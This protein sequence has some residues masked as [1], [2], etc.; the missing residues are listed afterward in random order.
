LGASSVGPME[1]FLTSA[2]NSSLISG[3]SVALNL[4]TVPNAVRELRF[5]RLS[6]DAPIGNDGARLGATVLYSDIWPSDDRRSVDTHTQMETYALKGS[7]VPIETKTSSLWL[8][9][10]AS[11]NEVIERNSLGTIYND[12]L[13]IASLTADYRLHDN[14]DGWNYLTLTFN[15]GLDVFGASNKGDLLLSRDGAPANFSI[16]DFSYTRY[17]NLSDAW[18]VKLATSGQL[19]SAP[20]LNSMQF[21]IGDPAYGPGFY[22]GD[23]GFAGSVELRFD[24]LL[25]YEL[26]KGYQ[27]YGFMDGGAVWNADSNGE[28]LSLSSAGMGVRFYLSDQLRTG[29]T[30]AAPLHIGTTSNDIRGVRILFSLSNS[31]KFCPDRP[32]LQCI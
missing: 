2:F 5:G 6:Y 4:S 25:Q 10:A 12:H 15:Q 20:L 24:Q 11:F 22:S 30:V 23:N 26:L 16:L 8:T 32:R 13:R 31:F 17:Q 27:I 7:I 1:A 9:A 21:Y 14:L 18:S 19:T 3:D 28:V 29:V